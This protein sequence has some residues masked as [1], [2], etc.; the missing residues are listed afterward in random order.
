[1][2]YIPVQDKFCFAV[3]FRNF[4]FLGGRR[5]K[6]KLFLEKSTKLLY[7]TMNVVVKIYGRQYEVI[8]YYSTTWI[9]TT[10]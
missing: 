6:C 9:C 2:V 4:Y 3:E 1:M 7:C 5:M 8:N 10:Q